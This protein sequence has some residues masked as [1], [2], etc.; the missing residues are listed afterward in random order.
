MSG[1]N[2][3]IVH[4]SLI[5]SSL[6][7]DLQHSLIPPALNILLHGSAS[8]RMMLNTM[9][10]LWKTVLVDFALGSTS[11]VQYDPD[12]SNGT[13]YYKEGK[14][15]D[16]A[17]APAGNAAIGHV[18]CCQLGDKLNQNNSCVTEDKSSECA[19]VGTTERH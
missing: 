11:T 6:H 14:E 7:L 4:C 18:F 2:H 19:F 13:C 16:A 10:T 8:A 5:L 3:M 12:I 17:Y 1:K 9:V 15:A